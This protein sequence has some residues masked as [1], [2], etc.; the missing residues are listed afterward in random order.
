MKEEELEGRGVR[1]RE[2][3]FDFVYLLHFFPFVLATSF[4]F[5]HLSLLEGFW[6]K[7][8]ET[9]KTDLN[10]DRVDKTSLNFSRL[11][12]FPPFNS[13]TFRVDT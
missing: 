1:V 7:R 8:E 2:R 11:F 10:N 4:L 3:D 6:R 9:K 13:A 12:I 5:L